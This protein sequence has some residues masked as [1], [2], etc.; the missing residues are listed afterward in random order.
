MLKDILE[1]LYQKYNRPE[2]IK[3]DPLQFVYRYTDPGDM[4]I[5]GFLAADLAYGRVQQI[6]KSLTALFAVMGR[7][8]S[9][10]VRSFDAA[11]RRALRLFKHRFTAGDD[12]SDLL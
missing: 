7:S 3:P 11:G 2:L 1:S 5:V 10:F 9:A 8:P 6:E 4:E 12:I